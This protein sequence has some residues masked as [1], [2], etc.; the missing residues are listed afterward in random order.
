[1]GVCV[2]Y[3]AD[4]PAA[5]SLL[6]MKTNCHPA[7]LPRGVSQKS[8]R[9]LHDRANFYQQ[10]K[11]KKIQSCTAWL[12]ISLTANRFVVIVTI[13]LFF[14]NTRNSLEL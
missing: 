4:E 14:A 9:K 2:R 10:L 12:W 8:P 11:K 6:C 3:K 7:P 5:L 13:I 1:M